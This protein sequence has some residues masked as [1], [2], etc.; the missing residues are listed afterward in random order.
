MI[1]RPIDPMEAKIVDDLIAL[2]EREAIR[3]ARYRLI[4]R[5]AGFGLRCFWLV[6]IG[7]LLA[8]ALGLT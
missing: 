4:E 6:C 1:V 8:R 2:K 5:V 3:D 7:I